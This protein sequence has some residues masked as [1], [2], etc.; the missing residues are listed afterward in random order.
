MRRDEALSTCV[1]TD[2]FVERSFAREQVETVVPGV[3]ELLGSDLKYTKLL[4]NSSPSCPWGKRS[5][6]LRAIG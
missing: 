5:F 3:A 1:D 6:G 4:G 2:F